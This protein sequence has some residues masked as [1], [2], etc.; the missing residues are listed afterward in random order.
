MDLGV[1]RD[2]VAQEAILNRKKLRQNESD[3]MSKKANA[4]KALAQDRQREGGH[5]EKAPLEIGGL[6]SEKR[7]ES[8]DFYV[9]TPLDVERRALLVPETRFEDWSLKA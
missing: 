9:R 3:V 2:Q 4:A 1:C 5:V 7:E 8:P 6:W